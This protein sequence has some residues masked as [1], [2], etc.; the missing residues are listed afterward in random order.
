[1]VRIPPSPPACFQFRCF[2]LSGLR[3]EAPVFSE[4]QF[5]RAS[6]KAVPGTAPA[7]ARKLRP[8]SGSF[9]DEVIALFTGS[10]A[11]QGTE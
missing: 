6:D 11:G 3:V 1:M 4:M 2:S 9:A 8:Q 7:G 5:S 10:F